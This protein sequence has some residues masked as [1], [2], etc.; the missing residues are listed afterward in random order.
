MFAGITLGNL[1]DRLSITALKHYHAD[2]DEKRES[3]KGQLAQLSKDVDDYLALVLSGQ[4]SDL[5][6]PANK[7]YKKAVVVAGDPNPEDSL[8]TL[9]S[10]LCEVNK[11]M[12]D[13]QENVYDFQRVPDNKRVE[14]IDVCASLNVERNQYIDAIDAKFAQ[15]M[16]SRGQSRSC[17][18][19]ADCERC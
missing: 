12:W 2:T 15:M 7:V 4:I 19:S 8:G 14:V 11:R 18:G 17:C 16:S 13:N 5:T 9:I 10:K 6:F 3:T 1:I